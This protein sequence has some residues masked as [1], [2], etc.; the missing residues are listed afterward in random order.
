MLRSGVSTIPT[1]ENTLYLRADDIVTVRVEL[2]DEGSSTVTWAINGVWFNGDAST[3]VFT[4]LPSK[5]AFA[6]SLWGNGDQ[7]TLL[8]YMNGN[9]ITCPSGTS[10][11]SFEDRFHGADIR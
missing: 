3:P 8:E 2:I 5:F 7:V 6:V 4:D 11:I 1:I 9:G 10:P